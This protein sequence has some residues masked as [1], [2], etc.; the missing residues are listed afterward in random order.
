MTNSGPHRVRSV[1]WDDPRTSRRDASAISGLDYLLA[2]QESRIQQPPVARLIG[3]R[4]REVAPGRA[5]FELEPAE[6]HYNPFSTVHGG[7]LTTLLDSAMTG[8]VL[9]T[10]PI[11]LGCSTLELKVNF[12]RPVTGTAGL[13]RCESNVI[14]VGSTV[15]TADGRV[16]DGAGKLYAHAS[17]TCAIFPV[18]V[19]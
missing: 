5:V 4:I 11:G 8:A 10:L 14:H 12:L 9:S 17:T 2:V 7:I 15:A 3:Y 19:P 13:L 16:V 1:T 6:Y 18:D